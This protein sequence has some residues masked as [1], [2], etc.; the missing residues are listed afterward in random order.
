MDSS[1]NYGGIYRGIVHDT[2]DPLSQNRI[3]LRVPQL[4]GQGVTEWAYP[5]QLA[6]TEFELPVVG[7]GVW[8]AFES[9]NPMYPIWLGTFLTKG[10]SSKKVLINNPSS[11]QLSEDFILTAGEQLDLVATLVG[12]SQKLEN[13][14][15]Q[16]T[17]L[18]TRVTTL[19]SQIP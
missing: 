14:Q 9:G 16:V 7:Q 13:L 1:Q 12:M 3:K 2:R 10:I 17:S 15:S 6:S 5:L 4:F 11:S 18:A 8:V 19:E